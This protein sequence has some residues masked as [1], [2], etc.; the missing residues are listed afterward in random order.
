[1]LLHP[2]DHGGVCASSRSVCRDAGD[3]SG[4][5]SQG[6]PCRSA[7]RGRR[8]A[9]RAE[10]GA[11]PPAARPIR[12]RY[13]R[14][15]GR[16]AGFEDDQGLGEPE[17]EIG[18]IRAGRRRG[19]PRTGRHGRTP[20]TP[21]AASVNGSSF[22]GGCSRRAG[23]QHVERGGAPIRRS[24]RSALRWA[25]R[26]QQALAPARCA[27]R[28][29]WTARAA[30]RLRVQRGQR[31]RHGPRIRP[32]ARRGRA[33]GA[34]RRAL[35]QHR[36]ARRPAVA[37]RRVE[38]E[39]SITPGRR[40]VSAC[41]SPIAALTAC[42]PPLRHRL[43]RAHQ[44]AELFGIE[45]LRP[46]GERRRR[47][48][49]HLDQQPVGAAA[50]RGERHRRDE[51]ANAGAV[52]GIDQDGQM[53]LLLDIGDGVEIE[54]VA[55]RGLEGADAALAQHH[56]LVAGGEQIFGGEQ[57]FLDLG[58]EA[59]LEQHRLARL[60]DGAEQGEILH[61][62]GADLQRVGMFGD[63][64]TSAVSITS[65]TIGRPVPRR[66]AQDRALGAMAGKPRGWCAA[67]RRRR[68]AASARRLDARAVSAAARGF[69]PRRARRSPRSRGR[70]CATPPT[71]TIVSCGEV[72]G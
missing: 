6:R 12:T 54:R 43:E 60:A 66:P 7:R 8:A 10:I 9:R 14:Q 71:S 51:V 67:C 40:R 13:R 17:D 4:A 28:G 65:V 50:A 31:R 30:P 59:A 42:G 33:A 44:V 61:V 22:G 15:R 25:K 46:V 27:D 18:E 69:R 21:A 19:G 32:A 52:R 62:A 24:S 47:I 2:R 56:L 11:R 55:G 29:R 3:R 41:A 37:Q 16:A 72:R 45:R 1:M 38:R 57:Q 36:V 39:R 5:A 58:R 35:E 68:A 53:G 26:E 34:G 48:V 49:V 70:R 64:S 63:E 23:T 20:T